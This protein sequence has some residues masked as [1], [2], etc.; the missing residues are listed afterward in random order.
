MVLADQ[1][2]DHGCTDEAVNLLWSD[3]KPHNVVS[4]LL[5]VLFSFV[6]ICIGSDTFTAS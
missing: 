5:T 2:Q 4:E 6:E 1:A 3:C